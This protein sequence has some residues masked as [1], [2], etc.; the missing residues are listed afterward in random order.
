MAFLELEKFFEKIV[1]SVSIIL[2][3]SITF[4]IFITADILWLALIDYDKAPVREI[5]RDYI[6]GISFMTLF[7]IQKAF[8]LFST[9]M[10]I[11]LNE[12]VISHQSANNA[13]LNVETRTEHEIKEIQKDYINQ[14]KD[15]K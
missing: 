9:S 3:N 5:I 7:I 1:C 2:G 14:V 11:K 8:N 6:H 10:H 12:L 15:Q 13:V 4:F